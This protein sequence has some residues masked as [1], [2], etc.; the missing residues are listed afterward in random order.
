MNGILRVA[1]QLESQSGDVAKAKTD[2]S[3]AL[4]RNK[5]IPDR[6]FGDRVC[7]RALQAEIPDGWRDGT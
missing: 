5:K 7:A 2:R 4:D 1:W 3:A 6:A